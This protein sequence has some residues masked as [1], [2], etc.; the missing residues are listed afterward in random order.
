MSD[1]RRGGAQAAAALALSIGL[2]ACDPG[3]TPPVTVDPEDQGSD[4]DVGAGD[5]GP[6]PVEIH[7]HLRVEDGRLVDESGERAQ[8][9]GPS[10]MWLNWES[11]GYAESLTALRWMR[12]NW[13]LSVIRA[14]MGIEPGGAYLSD[15]ETARSQVETIIQNAV[16]AGV[17]VLVDWHDHHAEQHQAEA[18]AFFADMASKY[19]DL[20]NI[21]YETFN[22][23]LEVS[24][25][26][27]LKPYH[28]AVIGAIRAADPDNVIVLGTP[29]WSQDADVAAKSPVA[30]ENLMYTLH[31][32]SCTHTGWLRDKGDA[33]VAAGAALFV[34]EWGA[35][36]A[37]GGL[38]GKTC[39]DEAS[40]WHAWMDERG[41]S[42]AAWKLDNCPQDATCLLTPDAP[43]DGGWTSKYLRGHGTFVRA[44][45]QEEPAVP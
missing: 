37:D 5:L 7:G 27:T 36:N 29:R 4:E 6:T 40:V 42:W 30:G 11:D 39:L 3:G 41:V 14:S 34:T 33:A 24:W 25:E 2:L 43:L 20:P 1:L 32:Y 31:F 35:T 45:M 8:L 15:P 9:K 16:E 19:G 12:N 28:E 38:D 23:P 22:E 10:S 26:S 18:E 17:Y 44:R 21:L 13:H